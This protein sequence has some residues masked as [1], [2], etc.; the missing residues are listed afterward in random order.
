MKAY[1]K[2]VESFVVGKLAQQLCN[3]G[4]DPILYVEEDYEFQTMTL[5]LLCN[6]TVGSCIDLAFV[7]RRTQMDLVR[8][9]KPMDFQRSKTNDSIGRI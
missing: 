3:H 7:R 9:E 8:W 1:T 2:E 6:E 5:D 4:H